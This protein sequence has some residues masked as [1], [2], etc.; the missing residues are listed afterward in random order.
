ME[1]ASL[2]TL[3]DMEEV[4]VNV[5]GEAKRNELTLRV[6][7]TLLALLLRLWLPPRMEEVRGLL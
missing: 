6:L 1:S 2:D 3:H 7:L 5:S 4:V